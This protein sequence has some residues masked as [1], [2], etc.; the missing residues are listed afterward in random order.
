MTIDTAVPGWHGLGLYAAPG[1][2]IQ[3]E[4]PE[5][6][7]PLGLS[8]QIGSHTDELW[9][10]DAWERSPQLVRRLPIRASRTAAANAFGGTVYIDV[11]EGAPAR[12]VEVKVAGAVE[13]P[14]FQ[15]GTTTRDEWKARVRQRPGPW[16][17]LEGHNVIFTVPSAAIRS[18]EDPEALMTLWDRIVAA[19]DTAVSLP[20][21][22]RPERIVADVQISAGYMHSGY[23]IMVPID[24]SLRTALS[25][26]RL[27][28]EGTWGHFHELG[29]N[30]QERDWTFDGT[31]EVTNNVLVLYV[32]DRVLGLP[33][34]SGHEAIRDRRAREAKIRAH[35]AAGAPFDK[36]KEDPFLAPHDV[37]P[38]LRGLRLEAVRGRLCRVP[39]PAGGGAAEVGRRQARPVAGAVLAGLRA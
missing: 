21:R 26:S 27:K 33:Y 1:A 8:V 13:A 11:P 14:R 36:W 20:G 22:R 25:V 16:A 3:V 2:A 19:Q 32:Y 34:D 17:E 35:M 6:A 15:L 9:H 39:P 23:P 7:V 29:H 10:L 28:R 30:H 24:D 12:K 5:S 37:H 18:L 38:A 4:V 31:G